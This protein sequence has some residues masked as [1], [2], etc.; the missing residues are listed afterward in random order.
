MASA[1]SRSTGT[2]SASHSR[3]R[4]WTARSA[5]A[6]CA[7]WIQPWRLASQAMPNRAI[8][9]KTRSAAPP[10]NAT[11]RPPASGP[12]RERISAGSILSPGI[13]CPPLRPEAP[14]PISHASIKETATPRSARCNAVES[15]LNPPPTTRTSA[16]SGA[17][18]PGAGSSAVANQSER[19]QRSAESVIPASPFAQGMPAARSPRS[20]ARC[21]DPPRR[22]LRNGRRPGR[23]R[24]RRPAGK[25]PDR[26]PS[27]RPCP[28]R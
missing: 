4:A 5:I 7:A 27:T 3:E 2:P 21:G 13:T 19:S 20:G 25:P 1:S 10:A 23:S 8:S 24:H 16:S 11:S 22:G 15:P 6:E 18:T 12:Q 26:P 14:K 17:S 9:S 28:W